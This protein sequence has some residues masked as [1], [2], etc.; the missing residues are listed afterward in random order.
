ME[1][2]RWALERFI[3]AIPDPA[4]ALAVRMGIEEH[5][6][7]LYLAQGQVRERGERRGRE[8]GERAGM[9][10]PSSREYLSIVV[11]ADT[12]LPLIP[13]TTFPPSCRH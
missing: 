11:A 2:G 10:C 7:E 9:E 1:E 8:A 13:R 12:I 5:E 4:L 3:H 6:K